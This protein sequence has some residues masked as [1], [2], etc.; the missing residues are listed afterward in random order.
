MQATFQTRLL[1]DGSAS[2][3][4]SA[5]GALH[6]R[7][8]RRLFAMF[9]AAGYDKKAVSAQK[10]AVCAEH[11]ITSRHFNAIWVMLQGQVASVQEAN[12]LALAEKRHRTKE[13]K[14]SLERL[15]KQK[16]P[17]STKQRSAYMGKKR[18]LGR[19]ERS[20]Q[21]LESGHLGLCFGSRKL[22]R[23]Q[24]DL[25][26]SGFASHDEWLAAW[27][28]ARSKTFYLLGSKDEAGGNQSCT[29]TLAVNGTLKLRLRL[30]D[31]LVAL[32]GGEKYLVLENV[33]F[34]HGQMELYEALE[35][36]RAVSYRFLRDA[37][38][39]RV[40]A[41]SE[42][43]DTRS[44]VDVRQGAV[45]V[46]INADHLAL[47]ETDRCGNLVRVKRIPCVTHGKSSEQRKDVTRRAAKEAVRFAAALGKPLVHEELD[48]GRRKQE[49]ATSSH[50]RYA[51]M[52][53][54]FAYGAVLQGI[55]SN[56]LLCGV[57]TVSVDP[58]YTS[59]IGRVKYAKS[60]GIS[61]HQAAGLVIARRGMGYGEAV[62]RRSVV[63]DGKGDHFAF[64]PPA[65]NRS[66]SRR[67][68]WAPV[69]SKLLET[70]AGWHRLRKRAALEDVKT[71]ASGPTGAGAVRLRPSN[72][73]QHRSAG[74]HQ[75]SCAS[76][77]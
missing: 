12:K 8:E 2:S 47:A 19:L 24:F 76:A 34:E 4:F 3:V 5:W 55:E 58:A 51:R 23:A 57:G 30:P 9:S 14:R 75:E 60:L 71:S 17:L 63:P 49:L 45:G 59:A 15:R 68:P 31:A 39:W 22:F 65:R 56:A 21:E 26:G 29:A 7:L 27:R 40:F 32:N 73:Q 38:G 48:F 52:L 10:P 25:E 6:G 44:K 16:T 50:P 46:D 53:S 77:A 28:D 54:S 41:S 74:V 18:R 66:M 69:R 43:P 72:R 70:L 11:R 64:E 62:P 33:W 37:K 35:A 61:V 42:R 1:L 67:A 36:G 13:L 20:I